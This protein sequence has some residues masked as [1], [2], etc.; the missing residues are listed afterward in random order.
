MQQVL[1]PPLAAA[2]PL[3]LLAADDRPPHDGRPWVMA[4]MVTSVD[5]AYAVAGRSG[6]L[7]GPADREVFHALRGLADV[8]LVAAGTAREE[9]YRR[10]WPIEAAQELR[11]GRSQ[12]PAA[13]LVVVSRSAHIPADQPFLEG[14]GPDPLVV[15]PAIADVSGLPAGVTTRSYG[16]DSV[17]LAALLTGLADDGTG[18][19]LCEGGPKLLGQLHRH[20]LLDE[21][22]VTVS[23]HLVGGTDVGMLGGVDPLDHTWKLHRVLE[24]DGFLLTT[25][26]RR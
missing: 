24:D 5:G 19:V 13:L 16:E 15:H 7:S 9:R 17:D 12:E 22:F 25:Y 11:R 18:L 26:R 14:D 2:H 23:P 8:V 1:P 10:P 3:E 6:T 4:N 21:L 20:D